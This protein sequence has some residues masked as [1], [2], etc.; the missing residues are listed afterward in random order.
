MDFPGEKLVIKMIESLQEGIG[1]YARPWLTKRD[2]RAKALADAESKR[3]ERLAQEK[4]RQDVRDVRAGRKVIGDDLRLLAAPNDKPTN[5]IAAS[6][7]NAKRQQIEAISDLGLPPQQW[8]EIERKINL[9]QIA[10]MAL[11]EAA[12][13]ETDEVDPTSVDPD[14]FTQWRNR[15]QDVSNEEMQRLWAK[16]LKGQTKASGSFSIHTMEFLS[17]M[18]RAD[19]EL[20]AKLGNFALDGSFILGDTSQAMRAAG[21]DI[22]QLV[23]LND[24]GILGGTPGKPHL[25][26]KVFFQPNTRLAYVQCNGK[27]LIFRPNPLD[28][29][30][31]AF[32]TYSI[33][34]VGQELL[35]LASCT[36]SID[37]LQEIANSVRSQC[38]E[39][40]IA[41]I[42]RRDGL[43][44][45]YRFI[46]S[47]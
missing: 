23:Y 2:A 32:P 5:E 1:T 14:W 27:A 9:D 29:E 11:E 13:D 3:I 16:A 15:A 4:L 33:T 28:R 18:S 43:K 35:K 12:A 19:A 25:E 7:L 21:I 46:G 26:V 38:E 10:V 20:I 8:V 45:S 6:V 39:I 24:L 47:I 44:T 17:R 34:T 40:I 30:H 42:T 31:I 41:E 37:Y 36:A 22:E